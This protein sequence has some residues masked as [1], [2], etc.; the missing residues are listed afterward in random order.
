MHADR[1]DV[2]CIRRLHACVAAIWDT[3]L[4]FALIPVPHLKSSWWIARL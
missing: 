1:Q 4:G 3:L 2:C